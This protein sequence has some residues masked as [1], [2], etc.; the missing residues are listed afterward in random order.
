MVGRAVPHDPSRNALIIL[1]PRKLVVCTVDASASGEG[2]GQEQYHALTTQYAHKLGV[3]GE[4]FTAFNMVI[5]PFGR[6]RKD[7]ICVQSMDGRLQVFD[8]D[9]VSFSRRLPGAL[10]PGPLC[11]VPSVDAFV[12]GTSD[13]RVE[14]YRYQVLVAATDERKK[15][16]VG[17]TRDAVHGAGGDG[18]DKAT[19]VAASRKLQC[20]WSVH[21]GEPA[22]HVAYAKL[23]HKLERAQFDVIVVGE[24]TLFFLKDQQGTIRMQKRLEFNVCALCTYPRA[25]SHTTARA[26]RTGLGRTPPRREPARCGRGSIQHQPRARRR[27]LI[28]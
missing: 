13:L 25:S 27:E 26:P 9:A 23:S 11:Y 22:L 24:H 5:G 17:D 16:G 20:D 6:T 28:R 21:L 14:S 2:G 19:T 8:Q 10:L 18:A 1:H 7:L 3:D 4:H 12:T 15:A